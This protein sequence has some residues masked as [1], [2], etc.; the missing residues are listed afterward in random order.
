MNRF[1][2][3]SLA[4]AAALATLPRGATAQYALDS[5]DGRSP[6]FLLAMAAHAP[7]RTGRP[8]TIGGVA[9]AYLA[10][11]RGRHPQRGARRNLPAG[12]A[13]PRLRRR[14]HPRLDAG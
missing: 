14:R 7:A 11:V 2:L 12:A 4:L 13:R 8:E 9:P 3:F 10:G 6:R 1:R 5:G